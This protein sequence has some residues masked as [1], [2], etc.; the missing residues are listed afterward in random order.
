MDGV[1]CLYWRSDKN[2][3]KSW[4]Y[5]WMVFQ[6]KD[7]ISKWVIRTVFT[8]YRACTEI[9]M[10]ES[11]WSVCVLVEDGIEA[12][13]YAKV[14]VRLIWII[15]WVDWKRFF[16]TIAQFGTRP[17]RASLILSRGLFYVISST[18]LFK[19]KYHIDSR[20]RRVPKDLIKC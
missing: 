16:I 12:A 9:C 4:I 11:E 19:N 1:F 2:L 8:Y 20:S 5:N 18:K 14:T 10:T 7:K 13:L 3:C 17:F 6:D 15:K